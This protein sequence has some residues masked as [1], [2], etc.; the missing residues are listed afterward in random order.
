MDYPPRD[1]HICPSCGTEFGY[2]DS[3]RTYDYLRSLWIANGAQWWSRNRHAPPNW[4]AWEQLK[5]A[6]HLVLI[7]RSSSAP[8]KATVSLN[9]TLVSVS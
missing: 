6:G 9:A 5:E 4:D 1:F 3:G 8:D 2:H 7:N